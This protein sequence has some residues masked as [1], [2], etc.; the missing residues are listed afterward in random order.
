MSASGTELTITNIALPKA[1]TYY[2]ACPSAACNFYSVNV[3]VGGSTNTAT[4]GKVI[5]DQADSYVF[6]TLSAADM[7]A[8]SMDVKIGDQTDAG[9]VNVYESA[10]INGQLVTAKDL[11]AD[12]LYVI[13][14]AGT[15]GM[16]FDFT[17][18]LNAE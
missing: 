11:G 2:I 16:A 8:A 9:I 15:N 1:D 3:V 13:K 5:A 6:A 18:V 7:A 14:V 10:V 4:G 12:Y 17:T